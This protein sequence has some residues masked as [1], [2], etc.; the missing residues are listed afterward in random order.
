MKLNF[1][2]F[3]ISKIT[4][5]I[6]FIYKMNN[7]E[8]QLA[9]D[10]VNHT[11]RHIF[12]TGKAG[13][14]KTTF[15]HRLK[16]K[17]P[18]RLAVVAP[19][20]VAAINARGVTIHSFFQMPF[21]PILPD[22]SQ[23][24]IKRDFKQKFSKK[25]IDIIKSLDLL[26]IDE[27]SMVRAD[28]LDAID[29]V[30]R[31]YNHRNKVFGGVQ[32]L[33]IGDLQQLSPVVKQQE[34]DLLKNYYQTP[35]F[36]SSKAFQQANAVNIELK[37][38]Y[39][40]EDPVF[41]NIL[42]EVRNNQLSKESAKLLNERYIPDFNPKPDEDY[43]LLT[44]HNYKAEKINR[45]KLD[46]LSGKT[47][48]Y[49]AYIEGKF[50]E[51][52]YPNDEKL[53]LKKGAQ[54]MFIKNDSSF[55]K[56]YYNGKIGR[57]S[58]IDDKNIYVKCPGDDTDIEVSRETWE[59][60]TYD[61]NPQTQQIE[62][63][64][65]GS[66][67]QIPLRLAWA[68]TI[69]KSQG[70]TFDK[71]IID[72][73]LSFAH[74]QTYVALSRC[75]TLE[76]LVLKTPIQPEAIINDS[77]VKNFT[78]AA[79]QKQPDKQTLLASQKDF[80][81]DSLQELFDYN[82]VRY[83]VNRLLTIYQQNSRSIQGEVSG[84]LRQLKT[85]LDNLTGIQQ[86]FDLQLRQLSKDIINPE[87]ESLIQER[88][89]KALQ[90]FAEKHENFLW[91]KFKEISFDIDNKQVKKD[92]LKF[93]DDLN[94]K[95][96][97][98][99]FIFKNISH[100]FSLTDYLNIRAKAVLL[101][102]EKKSNKDNFKISVTHVD[103][104]EALKDLRSELA[105]SEDVPH[106]QVFT[107]ETLYQLCDLLPVTKAQ[108]KKVHGIGKV[109]LNKY[110]E[111][112]IETILSYCIANNIELKDDQS[113][114]NKPKKNTKQ[115]SLEL[116]QSGKTVAEIAKERQLTTQTITKHLSSFIPTGEIKIT[117]LIDPERYNKIK[118]I[119]K[120]NTFE[121]LSELKKIAGDNYDWDE[122]RL[123]MNFEN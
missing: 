44:T 38:I 15:L 3:L 4:L 25:K 12:L 8:L 102:P 30:L 59:N 58:Y 28:L 72:A 70:L 117:D 101:K 80:F 106:F 91:T 95:L 48:Y 73:E 92:F 5:Y 7:H 81:L 35:Y 93:Y 79:S 31:K 54:V 120:N 24:K 94:Q 109:R 65:Q 27:I 61:I 62:E 63:K 121:G 64:P 115:I 110:G 47:Y 11:K 43:V 107:Q 103:L 36:F 42:N 114:Q 23:F 49:H 123:V 100:P 33:M 55:E 77:R 98:K 34:W 118:E 10:F 119:I 97:Q 19:T 90:Y 32:V 46:N 52:A 89:Q 69:H 66:F 39:R 85:G 9:W 29:Q 14:G 50:P 104:L 21:G 26:I 16:A 51:N 41:I 2:L 78:E 20:G 116:F 86:K 40:Q 18:K 84:P 76:G 108:L 56:R 105:Y 13:T 99:S 82:P 22:G 68:I 87:K 113:K 83:P 37:N 111:Q 74:G 67:S 75:K 60:I 53:A 122:L 57:I 71:A 6:I 96:T 88:I 112:I 17:S 45:E 1:Q